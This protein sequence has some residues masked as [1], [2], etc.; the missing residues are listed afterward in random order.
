[1]KGEMQ[2][3]LIGGIFFI[4]PNMH[5]VCCQLILSNDTATSIVVDDPDNLEVLGSRPVS[6]SATHNAPVNAN[7]VETTVYL[8]NGAIC[9]QTTTF[10]F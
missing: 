10:E 2:L 5:L 3:H 9:D 6:V 4:I 7:K 1:M 8:E